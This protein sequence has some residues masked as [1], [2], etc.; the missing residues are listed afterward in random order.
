MSRSSIVRSPAT[1]AMV[2]LALGLITGGAIAWSGSR[3]G[4]A[5]ADFVTPIGTIWVNALRMTVVPLVASLLI[6]TLA[7][8]R[9][10]ALVREARAPGD[11]GLFR[12]PGR[13]SDH[14]H[15]HG[16][17]V[18]L[19]ADRGSGGGR[20]VARERGRAGADA[21][22]RFRS[23][24]YRRRPL[25]RRKGRGGRRDAADHR[26]RVTASVWDSRG[27]PRCRLGSSPFYVLSR[28]R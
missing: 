25:Q 10:R 16:S 12:L 13:D 11:R 6:A 26:V 3:G 24:D 18:L 28:T 15:R 14:R 1:R 2:G 9:W 7:S 4:Q 22:A 27:R 20:V 23:V 5:F 19:A 8:G 17:A 21:G